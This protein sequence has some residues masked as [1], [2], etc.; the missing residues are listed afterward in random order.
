MMSEDNKDRLEDRLATIMTLIESAKPGT[1]E[2]EALKDEMETISKILNEDHKL[3]LEERRQ[4]YD[5]LKDTVEEKERK[6]DRWIKA[7]LGVLGTGASI[8][9]IVTN[10]RALKLA[11]GFETNGT[12]RSKAGLEALRRALTNRL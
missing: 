11:L 3:L 2:Y 7:G 4:T 10:W 6:I 8:F 1:S 5:S 12:F 9:G